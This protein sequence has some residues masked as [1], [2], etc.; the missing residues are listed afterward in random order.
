MKS[1]H[2]RT[3]AGASAY[4]G[5]A[6]FGAALCAL[7]VTRMEQEHHMRADGI[8]VTAEVLGF[9]NL[10]GGNDY[11]HYRYVFEGRAYEVKDLV[12]DSLRSRLEPGETLDVWL[13]PERPANPLLGDRG[14]TP[15]WVGLLIGAFL[16][17][18]GLFGLTQLR[19]RPRI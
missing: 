15:P 4:F 11:L 18:G 17:V 13:L 19:R 8:R 14:G 9:E 16:V 12:S 7:V 10:A 3:R 5:I 1:L 6:L 2:V